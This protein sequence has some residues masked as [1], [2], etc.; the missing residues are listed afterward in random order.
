MVDEF[1]VDLAIKKAWEYQLLAFPNPSVGAVVTDSNSK[2]LAIKAHKKAGQNHAEVE[3]IRSAFLHHS[4]NSNATKKLQNITNPQE[5]HE[6]L[7]KNSNAMFKGATIYVSLEPCNHYGKTPPCALLIQ[8][9][10]FSKVVFSVYD[11]GS[12]SCGGA[13][14]LQENGVEC[15]GGVLENKGLE[16][17]EPFLISQT[18]PFVLFKFAKRQNGSYQNGQIS[19]K[20]SQILSHKL[21][22][23]C[24]LM[25]IG[26]NTVRKDRPILDARAV[27]ARPPDVQILSRQ[28]SF[29]KSIPLF[30]VKDRKVTISPSLDLSQ[31]RFVFVEGGANFYQIIKEKI[32]W[33]LIFESN[34]SQK[35]ESFLLDEINFL[36]TQSFKN[37]LIIW[38]KPT[39]TPR[40]K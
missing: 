37:E 16:L 10:G 9:L 20:N 22:S 27:N 13:K 19:S 4:L 40:N 15:V 35:G 32:S 36:H 25:L 6:F 7:I 31:K 2:I 28:K 8:K 3:A 5:L 33:F 26:G 39:L 21:R 23:L 17:I 30:G 12:K 34:T 24:D 18:S 11:N 29:D 38:A 1:F 14:F